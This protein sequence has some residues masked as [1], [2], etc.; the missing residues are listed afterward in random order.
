MKKQYESTNLED[1]L[2]MPFNPGEMPVVS[3]YSCPAIIGDFSDPTTPVYPYGAQPIVAYKCE[4]CGKII[5]EPRVI[6]YS[7]KDKLVRILD[8]KENW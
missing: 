7:C 1:I 3:V 6:C 2:K 5:K 8:I 4:I